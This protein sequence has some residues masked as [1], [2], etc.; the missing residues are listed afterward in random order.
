MIGD[1]LPERVAGYDLMHRLLAECAAHGR[2]VYMIGAQQ[3]VIEQAVGE[4]E[5]LYPGITIAGWRNGYFDIDDEQVIADVQAAKPDLVLAALGME[6]QENWIA[7]ALPYVEKGVFIGVG[8]S[9]DTLTGKMPRAPLIFRK[10]NLEWFYRL[11]KQPSRWRRMLALPK[12]VLTVKR[13]QKQ[14]SAL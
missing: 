9:F 11:C 4:V 2:S 1:P 10:A 8:G 7:T 14:R 3:E 12:F 6:R 13:E 5:K